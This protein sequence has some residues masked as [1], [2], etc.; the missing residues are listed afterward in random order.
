[1][2]SRT[3]KLIKDTIGLIDNIAKGLNINQKAIKVHS[4]TINAVRA[5]L[6]KYTE[7]NKDAEYMKTLSPI[8]SQTFMQNV[9][10]MYDT[11]E[12]LRKELDY[13]DMTKYP[14][15]LL[16]ATQALDKAYLL[17]DYIYKNILGECGDIVIPHLTCIKEKHVADATYTQMI[18]SLST[19]L[20]A[21]V[22]DMYED[23][24]KSMYD[25]QFTTTLSTTLL[26]PVYNHL[27]EAYQW[28]DNEN[29][30]LKSEA[31]PEIA[32][33]DI[34]AELVPELPKSPKDELPKFN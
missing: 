1:M 31:I 33:I 34:P 6:E 25:T 2:D 9:K 10:A 21:Y 20:E 3:L 22:H 32:K 14:T 23:H 29:T 4:S 26:L 7:Q 5:K 8:E 30:R 13:L 24:I 27:I 19:E 28:M 16:N 15:Y 18:L 11:H 17:A 12:K